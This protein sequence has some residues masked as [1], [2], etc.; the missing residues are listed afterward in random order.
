MRALTMIVQ[1]EL[2]N[3]APKVSLAEWDN[4][5]DTTPL[6]TQDEPLG[7]RIQIG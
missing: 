3:G 2:L 6:D 4:P 7:I 1:D 5:I